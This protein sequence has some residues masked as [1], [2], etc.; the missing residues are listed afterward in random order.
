MTELKTCPFCGGKAKLYSING[1]IFIECI[2]CRCS[3]SIRTFNG[4]EQKEDLKS[5]LKH[6]TGE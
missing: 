6:G 3:T 5:L 1:I 4:Y 2:D